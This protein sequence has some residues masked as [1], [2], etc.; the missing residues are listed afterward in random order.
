MQNDNAA[1]ADPE[2]RIG[3][4]DQGASGPTRIRLGGVPNDA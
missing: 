3:L 1:E 2:Q 4:S